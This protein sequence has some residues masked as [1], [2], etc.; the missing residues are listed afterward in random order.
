LQATGA[1]GGAGVGAPLGR[2]DEAEDSCSEPLEFDDGGAGT[3]ALAVVSGIA[4]GLEGG[5]GERPVSGAVPGGGGSVVVVGEDGGVVVGGEDGGVVVLD[6]CRS[7]VCA[8]WPL[9]TP[10][11]TA[12]RPANTRTTTV[13]AATTAAPMMPAPTT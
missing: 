6:G 8:R 9:P 13:A 4:T 7:R 2:G 11:E 5:R 12:I 3:C 10:G 1:V